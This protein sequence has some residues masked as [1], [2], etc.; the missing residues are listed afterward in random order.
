MFKL[1]LYF[2]QYTINVL[3]IV[4]CKAPVLQPGTNIKMAATRKET[5]GGYIYRL[6]VPNLK[7]C[8]PLSIFWQ[9]SCIFLNN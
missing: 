4:N 5:H 6:F 1:S 2:S 9:I 8:P 7:W 3:R